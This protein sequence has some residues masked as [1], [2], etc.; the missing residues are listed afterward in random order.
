MD[1][2]TDHPELP[3]LPERA[4]RFFEA[5][6]VDPIDEEFAGSALAAEPTQ[7]R[8]IG[9]STAF[10]SIA[11]GAS[12][13]V[14][15]IREIIAASYFGV[16]P[17]DVGV[18]DRLPDPQP[19]PQPVRRRGAAGGVRPGLHRAARGGQ[20][21]RGV[22]PGFDVDPADHRRARCDHRPVHPRRAVAD[23]DARPRASTGDPG[24][25][26]RPLP[27][28]LPDPGAARGHRA[29]SSASS[30]ATT[31]S[32]SS[33]SRRSSGTSRSSR[34]LVGLVAHVRR[35]ATG[36][37]PTRSASS[38][39]PRSS[40]RWSPPDLRNTPFRMMRVFDWR[41]PLVKKVLAADAAGDDQPRPDQRQP[42]HQQPRRRARA[43]TLAGTGE[44]LRITPRPRSTRR[45]AS[46][47][48]R[49]GCSR[50][51]SRR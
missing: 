7:S 24:P 8:R 33:R 1:E 48:S 14:G 42:G 36:S 16:G 39:A 32:R 20:Q 2:S 12:R 30:T 38:S 45:S 28:P 35:E 37:T 13:L 26:R 6:A 31:A 4:E 25:D 21:T 23:P 43:G 29:S 46:T 49:R 9:R 17:A 50:S 51:R 18:H 22:P 15:L 5:L 44:A 11:T 47:C 27:A 40:W 10:F 3:P 19:R 41:S 34:V